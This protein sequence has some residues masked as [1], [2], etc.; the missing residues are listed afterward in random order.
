MQEFSKEKIEI[1]GVEYTLFLNRKGILSW[2]NITKASKKAE[3]VQESRG[4]SKGFTSS[5]HSF[6]ELGGWFVASGW[7]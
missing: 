4:G 5:I 2:E 6:S 1:A 7:I 3:E